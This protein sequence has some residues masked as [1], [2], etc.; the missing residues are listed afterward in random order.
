M[1][2]NLESGLLWVEKRIRELAQDFADV[3]GDP[4]VRR[5][6][7]GRLRDVLADW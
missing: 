5:R 7:E 2:T 1:T 4:E 3:E 6:L